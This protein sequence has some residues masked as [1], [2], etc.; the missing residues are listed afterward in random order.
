ML[1]PMQQLI[2]I[3]VPFY[4][5]GA[6]VEVF[7][8]TIQRFV[9][10]LP[11]VRFEMV[12]VDDGSTDDTLTRLRKAADNDSRYRV[13]EL[14]RNFGK[15]AALTAGINEA[16]GDAV[17][18]MD[19]DMQDSPELIV[20]MLAEWRAGADM[21]LAKRGNRGKDS[22]FKRES[23]KWFYRF[24]N[25]V[26]SVSIPENVGDFRLLD[27]A[28]VDALKQLPEQQRFMKGL[29][30]WIGFRTKTLEYERKERIVGKSKFSVWKLWNFALDGI[31]SFSTAPLRIWT[32]LGV[33]VAL[34]T[35]VYAG[36]MVVKK[37]TGNV[38]VPG[39]A[40][41]FVAVLFLGSLQLISIGVLG[42][43]IGRIYIESK[44]RP[45]Y[46]VRK[47]YQSQE[48]LPPTAH[49]TDLSGEER[50]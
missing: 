15:E 45:Q 18:P 31:T 24:H 27:R 10:G 5:E 6:G 48:N 50:S 30:A 12:C 44:R 13:I 25:R 1:V 22:V 8:Q 16:R 23:A 3:V 9:D 49:L 19:A 39:Y 47:I 11:D 7:Y 20:G 21:V 41:L 40:S 2:S 42:E 34:L 37:L 26:S 36:F 29:F 46:I 38:D 43:Y 33:V 17:I 14:S 35:L 32:Y 4:N 28:A